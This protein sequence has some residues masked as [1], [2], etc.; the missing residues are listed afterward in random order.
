MSQDTGNDAE[1]ATSAEVVRALVENHRH[2]LAF[3]ERR[4]GSRADA[5]DVLQEAFARG[6][7]Q[8]GS[9]QEGESATAWFYRILRNAVVDHHRRRAAR[10]RASEGLARELEGAVEPPADVRDAICACVRELATTLK[11][12]YQ[13]ALERVELGGASLQEY[14][15]EARISANNAAVRLHRAREALRKRVVSSC[16]TCAEHGCI[17][18]TCTAPKHAAT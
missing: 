7:A 9:V 18:C 13:G 2:F 15:A 4:L 14:A 6:V 17:D 5:E 11:P 1:K 10:D 3:L 8:A 16:G 12:E